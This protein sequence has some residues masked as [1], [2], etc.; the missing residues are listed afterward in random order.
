MKYVVG[1]IVGFLVIAGVIFVLLR[2]DFG[3]NLLQN[4]NTPEEANLP[5][6]LSPNYEPLTESPIEKVGVLVGTV[7]GKLCYP[8]EFLPA[9]TIEAKE[10]NTQTVETM[11]YAG[12]EGNVENMYTMAL[13]PGT[14]VMRYN[15]G[16]ASGYHTHTCPTGIEASCNAAN[17]REHIQVRVEA[18]EVITGVDLCDFYYTPQTDPGF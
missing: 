17:Q 13:S 5:L 11:A 18:G 4:N 14:Y 1:A 6:E 9:G 10:I 8:S 16:F 7:S 15:T 12:S 2:T 3:K